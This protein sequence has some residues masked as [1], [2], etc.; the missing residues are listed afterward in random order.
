[1]LQIRITDPDGSNAVILD[2]AEDRRIFDTLNSSDEGVSFKIA[3]NHPKAE[4]LN[5][6]NGGYTKFWEAWDTSTNERKNHGQITAINEEGVYWAVTGSGRSSLFNDY[7][8]SRKTFYAPID[9]FVDSLRFENISIEPKTSTLVHNTKVEA[10]QTTVLGSV[11]V[12]EEYYGLSKNTKDN[13]IDNTVKYPPEL[14]ELPNTYY[15]TPTYW[16]GMSRSD[17]IIVDLGDTFP[18]AR[19]DISLPAWGGSQRLTNRT[20]DFTVAYADDIETPITEWSNRDFGPFHEIYDTGSNT[21]KRSPFLFRLGSNYLNTALGMTHVNYV[22]QDKEG[23]VDLR[24]IRVNISDTH[25]WYG[26]NWSGVAVS[27]DWNYQCDPDEVGGFS[28][29]IEISDRVLNPN[30]DCHASVLEISAFKEII[31][32]DTIKP[33]AL[34]RIDNDNLQIK[35]Y[36]VP[37]ASETRTTSSGFRAFEPGGFFRKFHVTYSGAGSTYTKF[38]ARD[39]ANCYPDGFSF[40]IVDQNN[41][42]IYSSDSS[43]GTDVSIRAPIFTRSVTM[44]GASNAVVTY[45]DAWK[46]KYDPLSWGSAYSFTEEVGDYATVHFR[47]QSFK[48]YATVPSNKTGAEV[49]IQIR[50][51]DG[52]G[53]W[54]SFTTLESSY[55]IPNNI[56]AYPVYE[57]TYESGTLLADT[58]YEIKIT[59]LDGNYCSID[60]FEGYWSA[61]MTNYNDDS[62]KVFHS[63]PEAMTQIYD[64]RFNNGTMTKWNKGNAFMSFTFE[65]DRFIILS[66]KGRNHGKLS[67]FLAGTGGT[68]GVYSTG[69][70]FINIPGGTLPNGG[71][72]IDLDTGKRGTEI[73]QYVVMDSNDTFDGGLP[74][75]VYKAIVTIRDDDLESYSAN[76]YD[77]NNFVARCEDCKTAKGTATIDKYIYFDSI[78]AHEKVGLS[79]SFENQT[80]LEM[81]KSVAEAIQ[82]EWDITNEGVVLDPRIG[83]D[84]N[85]ILREG[86][87]TMV[88]YQIVNDVS[89]VASMLFS[90]G[91]DIDG[92]PLST[93]TEDRKNRETLGRT[94]MRKE[95]FRNLSEYTQLIGLSRTELRKRRYPEKR[96]T[97]THVAEEL[98]LN[99]GD[100]FILYTKKMGALRVR[101]VRKE[102]SETKARE[103]NLECIRW[104]LIA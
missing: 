73:P 94:V 100:S 10:N 67:I 88:D 83:I 52:S 18:I 21:T 14:T 64:G 27:A 13:A 34:Q 31:G 32:L 86:H 95:D 19:L 53:N 46:S 38:Y 40:G 8:D 103:Y 92:L 68:Q 4:V 66:A 101:I 17:A 37:D 76:I 69:T 50:N 15:V 81:L 61:S 59:N 33:L 74:W 70:N 77:T 43:S 102:I 2:T 82:T 22:A 49:R 20:Y 26:D 93:V 1:M 3:K 29:G 75:G 97:V 57:I 47:G 62:Q 84:T 25:A 24:Y 104:P 56:S 89:K 85:E 28:E 79:V 12:D 87:N 51:K 39:C 48:W 54:T 99:K 65:G 55:T 96:I 80:H 78:Y 71:I 35:Y 23:P 60:S 58:V 16:S 44:K 11:T 5:P 90:N 9:E 91:A 41:S 98:S 6:E 7:I 42:L 72:Q 30:N 63:R 45:V 36:H